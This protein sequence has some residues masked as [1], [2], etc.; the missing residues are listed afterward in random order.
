MDNPEKIAK[1]I[2]PSPLT[3]PKE[4]PLPTTKC[5]KKKNASCYI[6]AL[7]PMIAYPFSF[8]CLCVLPLLAYLELLASS[9]GPKS[10]THWLSHDYE[11]DHDPWPQH[12]TIISIK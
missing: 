2:D 9:R 1:I 10:A 3:Q 12:P 6:N 11:Q 7:F 8:M 5:F 4:H